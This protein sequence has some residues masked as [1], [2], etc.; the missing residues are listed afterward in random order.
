[1]LNSYEESKRRE[2]SILKV[3]LLHLVTFEL[4]ATATMEY[5]IK[6]MS[7]IYIVRSSFL[8]KPALLTVPPL[9][10]IHLVLDL[11]FESVKD[12]FDKGFSGIDIWIK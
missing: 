9:S 6:E 4:V 12:I 10:Y 5:P 8:S 3:A 1:M 7:S 2:F 11:N